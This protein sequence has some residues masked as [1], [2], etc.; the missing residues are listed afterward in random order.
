MSVVHLSP[1]LCTHCVV[2]LDTLDKKLFS[3]LFVFTQVYK[4]IPCSCLEPLISLDL[5]IKQL[6]C[7]Q[8]YSLVCTAPVCTLLVLP[9]YKSV[10]VGIM[11]V[12]TVQCLASCS[13]G[14]VILVKSAIPERALPP[15]YV[16]HITAKILTNTTLD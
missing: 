13:G 15:E 16:P 6:Y 3:T 7:F 12:V 4:Q 9:L 1:G 8:G 14:R 2:S 10:L 11:L 5:G